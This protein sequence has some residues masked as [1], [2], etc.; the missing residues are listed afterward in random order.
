MYGVSHREEGVYI[1]ATMMLVAVR[2]ELAVS[3]TTGEVTV[4]FGACVH[5]AHSFGALFALAPPWY[6]HS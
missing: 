5:A 4:D 6:I 1:M 2:V 3:E